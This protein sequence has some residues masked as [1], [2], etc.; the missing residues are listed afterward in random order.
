MK[1]W[2]VFLVLQSSLC[3]A[4]FGPTSPIEVWVPQSNGTLRVYVPSTGNNG[5]LFNPIFV[6][7]SAQRT[8]QTIEG[9]PALPQPRNGFILEDNLTGTPL[10]ANPYGGA[11]ETPLELE[12]I[13]KA[14]GATLAT[15]RDLAEYFVTFGAQIRDSKFPNDD[16]ST[17]EEK[18]EFAKNTADGYEP[19]YALA[20][21][22]GF[23][24]TKVNFFYNAKNIKLPYDLNALVDGYDIGLQFFI[25][26]PE[27]K[28]PPSTGGFATPAFLNTFGWNGKP[29]KVIDISESAYNSLVFCAGTD[30]SQKTL[31]PSKPISN[32][33][34]NSELKIT[35]K[36]NTPW[37]EYGPGKSCDVQTLSLLELKAKDLDEGDI[38][39]SVMDLDG[40]VL[41]WTGPKPL[42]LQFIEISANGSKIN[43]GSLQSIFLDAKQI[44]SLFKGSS[45]NGLEQIP[46]NSEISS[47]KQCYWQAGSFDLDPSQKRQSMAGTGTVTVY[48]TTPDEKGNQIAVT[49]TVS[50]PFNLF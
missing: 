40:I 16:L 49:S 38:K 28:K 18:A 8:F 37:M 12:A 34:S 17:D 5:R 2:V 4:D 39:A 25:A 13:C 1:I 27:Y 22:D 48:G 47:S 15:T 10:L 46:A 33:D 44:Q 6:L 31:P 24:G 43:G 50:F 3:F 29:D 32:A 9:W 14:R 7:D 41:N 26:K 21:P 35:L 20:G 45:L 36:T 19:I 11:G 42:T 23:N 30:S